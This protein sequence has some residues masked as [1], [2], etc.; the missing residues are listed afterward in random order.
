[1]TIKKCQF[2]FHLITLDVF[3]L[4]WHLINRK[5]YFISKR[6]ISSQYLADAVF[7]LCG[8][9]KSLSATSGHCSF[10][11][12]CAELL[13]ISRFHGDPASTYKFSTELRP[14]FRLGH[15]R[16]LTLLFLSSIGF[17]TLAHL[18]TN[19]IPSHRCLGDTIRFSFRTSL[20]SAA[21]I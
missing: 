10:S 1:M 19:Y 4:L 11:F 16:T 15:S 20:Q 14:G 17:Y 12:F 21:F 6:K 8:Y 7:S 18:K 9:C 3:W 5:Y 13:R 2:L